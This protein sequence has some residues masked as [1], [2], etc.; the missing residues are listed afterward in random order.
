MQNLCQNLKNPEISHAASG[1]V[2]AHPCDRNKPA[3]LPF[4]KPRPFTPLKPRE[5]PAGRENK[6]HILALLFNGIR[7]CAGA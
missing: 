4:V 6:R 2:R 7:F 3:I 1:S 5:T